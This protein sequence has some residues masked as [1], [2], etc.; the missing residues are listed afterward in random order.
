MTLSA[1]IKA[2]TTWRNRHT[3]REDTILAVGP[4][5]NLDGAWRIWLVNEQHEH[6]SNGWDPKD[7]DRCW[8]RTDAS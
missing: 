2:G 6:P 4:C 7:W 5:V 3:G 1:Q 8:E